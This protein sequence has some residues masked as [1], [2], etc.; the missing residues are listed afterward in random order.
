MSG[1]VPKVLAGR[2]KQQLAADSRQIIADLLD[3]LEAM[4]DVKLPIYLLFH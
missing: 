4:G 1:Q 2:L 3:C